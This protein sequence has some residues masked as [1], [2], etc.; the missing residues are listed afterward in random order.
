MRCRR[1]RGSSSDNDRAFSVG[2]GRPPFR[3]EKI[4]AAA[5]LAARL[6]SDP[7]AAGARGVLLLA[8][9]A[10][11]ALGLLGLILAARAT[12]AAERLE[13][14]EYEALGV[15]R[16]TLA[17]STQLRLV[18][19]SIL[20]IGAGFLGG[21]LAVRLIGAL[22]AVTGTAGQPLPPIEPVVAWRADAVVISVMAAAALVSAALLA[23]RALRETA[24]RRLRA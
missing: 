19:L 22:V 24:A 23:R 7:L 5:P 18:A 9:A 13:L 14:A 1:R 2:L 17:R 12:L 16:A 20:G 15:R 21:L 3:V 11:A 10:A 8:A 4:V 6:A